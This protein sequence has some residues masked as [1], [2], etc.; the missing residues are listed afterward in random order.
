MPQDFS[1]AIKDLAKKVET[2]L[3][4]DSC[5]SEDLEMSLSVREFTD[6]QIKT[7]KEHATQTTFHNVRDGDGKEIESTFE[8]NLTHSFKDPI[9]NGAMTMSFLA[10]DSQLSFEATVKTRNALDDIIYNYQILLGEDMPGSVAK[11]L[12]YYENEVM[13]EMDVLI[14]NMEHEFGFKAE[15][16]QPAEDWQHIHRLP[17]EP[18]RPKPQTEEFTI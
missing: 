9:S 1:N 10:S 3:K 4:K 13:N 12:E 6:A 11:V 16:I 14:E 2:T 17:D 7:V 18:F 15:D 5:L 8:Q